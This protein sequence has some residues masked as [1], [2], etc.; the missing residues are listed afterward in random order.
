MNVALI[1]RTNCES[2]TVCTTY[3]SK[4]VL[5]CEHTAVMW[6]M[7]VASF[8]W[9]ILVCAAKEC[10]EAWMLQT[11]ERLLAP[12][13]AKGPSLQVKVEANPTMAAEGGSQGPHIHTFHAEHYLVQNQGSFS[14]WHL[15]GLNAEASKK[16]PVNVQI[17][18]HYS[19]HNSYLNGLLVVNSDEGR[20]PTAL[21]MTSED[22]RW[23]ARIG[24][25][26]HY[27]DGPEHLSAFRLAGDRQLR[28]E[29]LTQK[30]VLKVAHLYTMCKPGHH[31]NVK[32]IMFS[33]EHVSLVQGQLSRRHATKPTV[34]MVSDIEQRV[35]DQEF[36]MNKSWTELG[37]TFGASAYLN[38]VNEYPSAF[39]KSCS[40]EDETKAR[41]TCSKFLGQQ[42][43]RPDPK[44]IMFKEHF[45]QFQ[46]IFQDCIF[47][48]CL[49]GGEIAAELAAEYVR[50]PFGDRSAK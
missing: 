19:G 5:A 7:L 43:P 9:G 50:T 48:V 42:D 6:Q 40:A 37:G 2:T 21:E 22:C 23:R 45:A 49:G 15:S 20:Q 8:V 33:Q 17:F 47:D 38:Q 3:I 24:S 46:R 41:R 1:S 13:G 4:S 28:V 44:E 39:L 32:V 29:M 10:E 11:S 34:A 25:D 36:L 30:E 18:A 27:V 26:W 12:L 31:I 14:F 16:V 35:R